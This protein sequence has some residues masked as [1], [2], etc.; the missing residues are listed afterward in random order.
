MDAFVFEKGNQSFS[1]D[2]TAY[3]A[4]FPYKF[5]LQQWHSSHFNMAKQTK[6]SKA[7]IEELPP[8]KK[9]V[10][11][12]CE[13]ST[14]KRSLKATINKNLEQ[15]VS[16]RLRQEIGRIVIEMTKVLKGG[17]TNLHVSLFHLFN[18]GTRREIEVE[19]K[20][21]MDSNHLFFSDYFRGLSMIRGEREGYI[22]NPTVQRLCVQYAIDPPDIEGIGNMYNFSIKKYHVNFMNN[23][24]THAYT[25]MR[26]FFYAQSRNKK[27]IYDTLHYLFHTTSE[28]RP[29][30][31]LI[32]SVRDLQPIDFGNGRGYFFAIE[33]H[34]YRFV[35][36][37]MAIQR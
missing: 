29:D 1:E 6:R 33:K 15:I 11:K 3:S 18:T 24:C 4:I 10:L 7:A 37:F 12:L 20:K 35:P 23:I 14:I 25:R 21:H 9:K 17:C 26:K 2:N 34:W 28:K 31:V 32:E 36:M 19:F 30:P 16:E 22:L 13:P 27:R 5:K 8:V